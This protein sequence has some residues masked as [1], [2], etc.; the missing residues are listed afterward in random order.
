[1]CYPQIT[2]GGKFCTKVVLNRKSYESSLQALHDLHWL[3]ICARI[4]FKIPMMVCKCLHD[5]SSPS[6]LK[7]LLVTNKHTGMYGNLRSNSQNVDLLIIPC[8][9]KTKLATQAFSVCG[10]RLWNSLPGAI[11]KI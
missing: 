3:P 5:K 6:Y 7:D 11:R 9:K 1:M 10:P 8:I 2:E 4:D